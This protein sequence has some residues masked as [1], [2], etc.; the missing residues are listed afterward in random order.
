MMFFIISCYFYVLAIRCICHVI[1]TV[2]KRTF[3]PYKTFKQLLRPND[4]DENEKQFISESMTLISAV[5]NV[6]TFVRLNALVYYLN[7]FFKRN[8]TWLRKHLES[9]PQEEAAT[10]WLSK[11]R[12]LK[13]VLKIQPK[14][15]ELRTTDLRS[16]M[17]AVRKKI[18]FMN[19]TRI[20]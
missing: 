15:N 9:V 4:L 8:H 12:M 17:P 16:K 13:S 10:R 20:F 14:L 11:L 2:A 1:N 3:T 5:K 6:G 18:D 19:I 7:I